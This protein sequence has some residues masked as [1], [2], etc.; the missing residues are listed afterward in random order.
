MKPGDVIKISI[1]DGKVT[2]EKIDVIKA[3]VE[4]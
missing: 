3:E 4:Q 1:S 2:I